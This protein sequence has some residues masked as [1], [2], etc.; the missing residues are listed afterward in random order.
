MN[1]LFK[2]PLAQLIKKNELHNRAFIKKKLLAFLH[3]QTNQKF[4][5]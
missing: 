5:F 4:G 1:M 3:L 2:I